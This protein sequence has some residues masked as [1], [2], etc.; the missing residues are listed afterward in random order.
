MDE[1]IAESSGRTV[2]LRAVPLRLM[3]ELTSKPEYQDPPV[4]T[5]SV[6]LPGGGSREYP[7]DR[8]TLD[9]DAERAAWA[10]YEAEQA[11]VS[12]RRQVATHE[13]LFYNGVV[14]DPPPPGDWAFDFALWGLEPPDPADK[15][16]YK[17]RWIEEEVCPDVR[18][19]SALILRLYALSG[20]NDDIIKQIESF[21]RAALAGKGPGRV[22][23]RPDPARQGAHRG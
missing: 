3:L 19:L 20:I 8:T 1:F 18:D 22:G 14:E 11:A 5:Y 21:F 2:H 10:A 15:V 6:D 4:P 9:T 7:H 23:R 16:A 12:L 13:F 17:R